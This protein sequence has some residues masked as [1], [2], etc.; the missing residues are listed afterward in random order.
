MA[1]FFVLEVDG[2]SKITLEDGTGSL[3]LEGSIGVPSLS[4]GKDSAIDDS[5]GVLSIMQTSGK[6][7]DSPITSDGQGVNSTI[8][9]VN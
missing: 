5:N 7:V 2:T 6:G 3:L 1:S 9:S 4:I 8:T